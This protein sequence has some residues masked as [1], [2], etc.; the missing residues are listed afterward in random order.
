MNANLSCLFRLSTGAENS[1]HIK[2]HRDNINKIRM[3]FFKAMSWYLSAYKIRS[4]LWSVTRSKQ[5]CRNGTP[6]EM[7]PNIRELTTQKLC[8]L[9][10]LKRKNKLY[11]PFILCI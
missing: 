2:K 5:M 7:R 9:A 1:F 8:V 11:R 10:T 3:S 4:L 6:E